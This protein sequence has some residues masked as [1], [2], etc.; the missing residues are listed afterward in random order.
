MNR[1]FYT[2]MAAALL[3]FALSVLWLLSASQSYRDVSGLSRFE[4]LK[5]AERTQDALP[6]LSNAVLDA[7]GD[8]A[9]LAHGCPPSGDF[10]TLARARVAEYADASSRRLSSPD[11]SVAASIQA[12]QCLPMAP[13]SG[14]SHAYSIN[15]SLNLSLRGGPVHALR[16]LNQ[17]DRVQ[18]NATAAFRSSVVSSGPAGPWDVG[19]TCG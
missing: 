19:V 16:S 17:S 8:A 6:F 4:A 3:L 15:V 9:F 11:L 7:E 12:W 2:G 14:F 10:C 18:A 1:G 5:V 13:S